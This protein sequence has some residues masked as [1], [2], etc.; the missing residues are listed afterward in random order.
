MTQSR[1]AF[2]VL[3]FALLTGFAVRLIALATKSNLA[4]DEAISYISATGHLGDYN[5]TT[6]QKTPPYGRWVAASQ[7]KKTWTANQPFYLAQIRADQARHDIHPPLYFWLLHLWSL[8]VGVHLWTGPLLNLL[9][10]LFTA[11]LLYKFARYVLNEPFAPVVVVCLWFLSPTVIETSGLARQYCLLV[12]WTVLIAWQ[13]LML[14]DPDRPFRFRNLLLWTTAF[15]AGA[16]T[17]YHFALP[18]AGCVIWLIFKLLPR[19]PQ[20]LLFILAGIIAGLV[21]FLALHPEFYISF[22]I[23][24]RHTTPFSWADF[25]DRLVRVAFALGPYRFKDAVTAPHELVSTFS[26]G[27]LFSVFAMGIYLLLF[28]VLIYTALLCRKNKINLLS[29]LRTVDAKLLFVVYLFLWTA[30]AVIALYLSLFSPLHAMGGR[31]LAVA[32]PFAAFILL[33]ILRAFRNKY[34]SAAILLCSVMALLAFSFVVAEIFYARYRRLADPAVLNTE[35]ASTV[36]LDNVDRGILPRLIWH[37]PDDTQV[38][39]AHQKYLIENQ[40]L[41]T[42]QLKP[43]S[44][45][46]SQISRAANF[47]DREKILDIIRLKHRL[48]RLPGRLAGLGEVYRICDQSPNGYQPP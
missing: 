7:W 38:F 28:A 41:W 21:V 11:L 29:Y 47:A 24:Q 10:D 2:A 18:V 5:K 26:V 3:L 14:A 39:A 42:S 32:W 25:A 22:R 43:G 23:Q 37:L 40:N 33:L 12:L 36:I 4:H 13:T 48:E 1:L 15:T 6:S 20:R 27:Q 9:I 35:T 31:Y 16:L 17:H 46:I 30:G 19:R 8:L 44:L 34:T 45:Y